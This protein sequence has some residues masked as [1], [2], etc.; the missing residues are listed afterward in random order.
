ML[1]LN[2][3]GTF[4]KRYN[5]ITGT[6]DVPYD[7]RAVEEIISRFAYNPTVAGVLYKD[8]LEFTS[9]DRKMIADIILAST[10]K[11]IVIIHGTDTMHLTAAYLSALIE[12]KVVVLTGAMVPYEIDKLEATANFSMALGY[13]QAQSDHGIY[14]CMQGLVRSWEKLEKNRTSGRFEIVQD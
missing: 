10:E 11:E 6:L 5:P 8:S 2:T 14:I 13:A 9:D 4:N 7:N 12:D 1:I 3:G